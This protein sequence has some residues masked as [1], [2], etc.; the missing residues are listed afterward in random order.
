MEYLSSRPARLLIAM[1]YRQCRSTRTCINP[2]EET[3]EN[4]SQFRGSTAIEFWVAATMG[5]FY[6]SGN[7]ERCLGIRSFIDLLP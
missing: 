7:Y 1:H 2:R 4:S 6:L 3:F 5:V